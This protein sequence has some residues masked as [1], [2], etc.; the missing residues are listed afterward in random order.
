[1]GVYKKSPAYLLQ[2]QNTKTDM[3]PLPICQGELYQS[4][5]IFLSGCKQANPSTLWLQR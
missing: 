2:S 5:S 4:F 3:K 1:M